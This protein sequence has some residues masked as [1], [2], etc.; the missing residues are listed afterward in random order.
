MSHEI[1][2]PMNAIIGL[3]TLALRN[4]SL[5]EETKGYLEKI[6]DRYIGDDTKL[7]Q[8]LINIL[9]NAIKFAET[10][11]SVLLEIQKVALYGEQTT[12]RFVIRDTGIG[13]SETFLP[14]IFDAFTQENNDRS[15]KYGSTGLGMAI[16]KNIVDLMNGTINVASK[17][18]KGTE[19]TVTLSLKNCE[20]IKPGQERLM[21]LLMPVMD[22]FTL[23]GKIRQDE[24]MTNIP[25][26]VMTSEKPAEMQSI[27]LGADDFIAK[28]YDMPEE[29]LARCERIIGLYETRSVLKSAEKDPLTRLY[30]REFF[31]EYVRQI[32]GN[33]AVS[34]MDAIVLNIEHFHTVNELFG[35]HV[36]MRF[37]G[38]SPT[39]W[40][41]S[42]AAMF[43]SDAVPMQTI[44]MFT[45]NI[46]RVMRTCSLG[47]R[48]N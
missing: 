27:K 36:G 38:R 1:R 33:K 12:F 42:L 26:I 39:C 16:T 13:M 21:D 10:P 25:V 7:K 17:Q 32:D 23:L 41:R 43:G 20:E 44:S 35:R 47:C 40:I 48:R 45:W 6:G 24:T 30:T 28:P 46:V 9:S 22:G 4:E 19:F 11:G 5:P 18:G 31:K 29:I 2:T 14:K 37:S 3:D 8:I 34:D 15:N